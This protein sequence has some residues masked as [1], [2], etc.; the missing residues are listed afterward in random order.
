MT[1]VAK[2]RVKLWVIPMKA[3]SELFGRLALI[4]Q[5]RNVDP[6]EVFSYPMGPQTW[7]LITEDKQSSFV[8]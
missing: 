3:Q 8:A 1:E 7:P 5:S 4:M 2:I 6:K